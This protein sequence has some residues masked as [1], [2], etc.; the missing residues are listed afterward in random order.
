[1]WTL[2][3]IFFSNFSWSQLPISIINKILN[4]FYPDFIRGQ[5]YSKC[6]LRT[7]HRLRRS[8][9]Y[10]K[11][12]NSSSSDEDSSLGSPS[13]ESSIDEEDYENWKT[14]YNLI[15]GV[16]A[17]CWYAMTQH[18]KGFVC[19]GCIELLLNPSVV[20]RIKDLQGE[21]GINM[22]CTTKENNKI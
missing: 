11:I 18:V 21:D 13:R 8:R 5:L 2:A 14:K 7:I 16:C 4:F 22:Y 19:T 17:S 9:S 6:M 15:G 3:T 20:E 10:N 1:M 12:C